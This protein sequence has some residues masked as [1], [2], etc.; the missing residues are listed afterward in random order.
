MSSAKEVTFTHFLC[1]LLQFG[2]M[3]TNFP[4]SPI[5]FG[6]RVRILSSPETES[7]GVVGLIGQVFGKTIL[8]VTNIEVIGE[9]SA[10]YAFN[11]FFEERT[12]SFWF[13]PELVEFTDH[14]P[15]TEIT[16]DGVAKKWVRTESGEWREE[17]TRN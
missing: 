3:N 2:V 8:S 12:E 4:P 13:A 16:L 15:G 1:V 17:S 5:S 10:D 11:V 6:D 14:S 9:T 7:M